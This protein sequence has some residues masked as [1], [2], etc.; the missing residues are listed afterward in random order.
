M[1]LS[2][3]RAALARSVPYAA[4]LAL[5]ALRSVWTNADSRWFD[6]VIL[7]VVGALLAWHW[8]GYGE[9]VRQ[10]RP[11]AGDVALAVGVGMVLFALST[12]LD[13]FRIGAAREGFVPVDSD[14][15]VHWPPI[16][17]HALAIALLVPLMDELFWRSFLM[18][19]LQQPQ[20]E[21]VIPQRVGPKAIV[22]ATFVYTLAH[23]YWLAA[24]LAGLAYALL[25]LRTGKL[26]T[27]VVAHAAANTALCVWVVATSRWSLW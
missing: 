5:T 21:T 16:A 9:L 10:T 27:P 20:F 14:G 17:L 12:Q 24:A 7:A 19:W 4:Y 15:A 11:T 25:Y 18:R 26:W 22:L 8:R 23:P 6:A 1:A 3:S 2:L 13:G